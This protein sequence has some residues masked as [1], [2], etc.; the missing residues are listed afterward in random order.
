MEINAH[1]KDRQLSFTAGDRKGDGLDELISF[2]GKNKKDIAKLDIHGESDSYTFLRQVYLFANMVSVL[3]GVEV[4]INSRKISAS[5]PA[6]PT[7][8]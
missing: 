6:F 8:S 7:Y 5:K 1:Y 3:S 2:I 4:C